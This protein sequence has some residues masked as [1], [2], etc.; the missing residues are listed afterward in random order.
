MGAISSSF[1]Q[2]VNRLKMA[3]AIIKE[4]MQIPFFVLIKAE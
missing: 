2:P 4:L 1:L 3:T